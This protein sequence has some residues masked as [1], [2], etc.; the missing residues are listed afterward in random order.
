MNTQ[1]SIVGDIIALANGFVNP[2]AAGPTAEQIAEAKAKRT[3]NII[4]ATVLALAIVAGGVY[5][6][7]RSHK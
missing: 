5:L 3:R 7:K 4:I 1:K 6:Y 2:P